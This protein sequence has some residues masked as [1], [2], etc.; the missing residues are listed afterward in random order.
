MSEEKNMTKTC[1]ITI[2]IIASSL[3]ATEQKPDIVI[4]EGKTYYIHAY[5]KDFPLEPYFENKA[6][7]KFDEDNNEKTLT[8]TDCWRSYKAIW[9]IRNDKLTLISIDTFVNG[10]KMGVADVVGKNDVATWFSG[11]IKIKEFDLPWGPSKI[12]SFEK[13]VLKEISDQPIRTAHVGHGSSVASNRT[14]F[15]G[16]ELLRRKLLQISRFHF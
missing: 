11:N 8:S 5:G 9:Q 12:L 1:L 15:S 6:R 3:S 4:L 16:H 10:K 13:G 2:L 14:T 7:P